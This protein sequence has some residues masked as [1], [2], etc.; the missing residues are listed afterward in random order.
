MPYFLCS[1]NCQVINA[2]YVYFSHNI[3]SLSWDQVNKRYGK[4]RNI[5]HVNDLA[6][7]LLASGGI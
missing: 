2:L 3:E 7:A 5:L 1:G 6:R 4:F